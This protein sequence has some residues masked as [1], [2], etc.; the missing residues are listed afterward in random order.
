[1]CQYLKTIIL[2]TTIILYMGILDAQAKFRALLVGIDYHDANSM[3]PRL[4]GAVNDVNEMYDL[5][6]KTLG[7]DPLSIKTLIE[8]QATRDAILK[9]F[10]AWLIKGTE[11]GDLVFFQYAGHGTQVPDPFNTQ[12]YDPLKKGKSRDIELAEAFVPYDTEIHEKHKEIRQLIYDTELHDL[13]KQLSGRKVTLF[14]D[15]CHSGGI[16]RDFKQTKAVTRFLKFPWKLWESQTIAPANNALPHRGIVRHRKNGQIKWNPEYSFFAA[17]RYFQSAYEYPVHNGKNGAFTR[18][19]LDILRA[20]PKAKL[21]NQQLLN[22]AQTFIRNKAGIS[23]SLQSPLFIGPNEAKDMP[24][25]LLSVPDSLISE[26][27]TPQ[28]PNLDKLTVWVTGLDNRVR[29]DLIEAISQYDFAKISEIEPYSII[30]VFDDRAEI[31]HA[32]GKRIAVVQNG[33]NCVVDVIKKLE[34]EYIVRELAMM[35]NPKTPF[36]VEMWIDSPGKQ[37]FSTKDRVTLYYRVNQLPGNRNAFFTLINVAPDGFVSILYPGKSDFYT[38]PG[39]KQFINAPVEPG[40]IHSIPKKQPL[41]SEQ[42]VVVD[43]RIRLAEGQEYFKGIVTSEPVDWRNINAGQFRASF[44]GNAGR[45]FTK[46]LKR[47]IIR[48]R[49][50]GTDSIRVEVNP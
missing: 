12:A 38:G 22:Y 31:Y 9:T 48:S 26:G 17:V 6:T 19:V 15:C 41:S 29:S 39:D 36:S 24:F 23:E 18:S 25:M 4:G 10:Q 28:I 16:T 30:K 13:L 35:E 40:K 46:N 45:K 21:T 7:I 20:N 42:N 43:L 50:W 27:E 5:M 2:I 44:K 33:R 11:P 47:G 49:F 8:K 37:Q 34:S 14:L 3:I 1:M 32:T